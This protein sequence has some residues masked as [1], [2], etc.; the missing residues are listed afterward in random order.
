MRIALLLRKLNVSLLYFVV[1]DN[2]ST[3]TSPAND[4]SLQ[5]TF[6]CCHASTALDDLHDLCCVRDWITA[7]CKFQNLCHWLECVM[8]FNSHF[9]Y[10]WFLPRHATHPS[11]FLRPCS[12]S[13]PRLTALLFSMLTV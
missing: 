5:H 7:L 3:T 11:S 12:D 13:H 9:A 10:F 8:E 6:A 4:R 2:A 1:M